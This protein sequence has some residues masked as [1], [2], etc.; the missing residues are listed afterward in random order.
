MLP[1]MDVVATFLP[2]LY[3]TWTLTAIIPDG[4]TITRTFTSMEETLTFVAA[5]NVDK[6]IYYTLNVAKP[7]LT[8]KPSKSDILEACW[9]H[10]DLDPDEGESPETAK[11]RYIAKLAAFK[12]K[13]TMIIDSGN[14]I[15]AI[16]R[17]YAV[18]PE[19]FAQVERVSKW[20]MEELG[21]KAGTQN[22]DRI[23]RLPGTINWPN[24]VKLE[25]GCV[26]VRSQYLSYNELC[27]YDL[28][29]FELPPETVATT[30]SETVDALD[31]DPL[32]W[33]IHTGGR[34][35]TQGE[36]SEGVWWCLNEL[37]RR[38]YSP[39]CVKQIML[40]RGNRITTHIY[41]QARPAS[42]VDT[43]IESA[44]TKFKFVL[45][46]RTQKPVSCHYNL[47]IALLK[48]GIVV[49]YDE[50]TD[51]THIEGLE[52]RDRLTDVAALDLRV[53]CHD[54]Y[55]FTPAK[56]MTFE[57]LDTI[58]QRNRYHPVK[59][60]FA[61]L[62]W[63]G[64]K[65]L[66]H[67][68]SIY[69]QAA[70][71]PYT[72]TVGALM[73]V[74]AVRRIKYPGTKFDE[75]VVLESPVQGTNKSS[76]LEVLASTEWFSDNLPFSLDSKQVIEV[77]R[78]RLIVEA[79]ELSGMRRT[80]VEHMKAFLSRTV[81]R[82]RMAYDRKTVNV[83]RQCIIV[84]TTNDNKYL[85]DTGG[86]RRFWPVRV[87]RFDLDALRRDR[88]QLWAEAIVRENDGA[89]IQMEPGL[90]EV[91][92]EQQMDRVIN[93]P[94]TDTL[95][96]YL[97]GFKEGKITRNDVVMIIGGS[98]ASW[99]QDQNGRLGKAMET[100]GWRRPGS[101]G[102][103]RYDGRQVV[104]WLI[105]EGNPSQ[106]PLITA[107]KDRDTNQIIVSIEGGLS[108]SEDSRDDSF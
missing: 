75:M 74:A 52:D 102:Q 14:G 6:N 94:Y 73:L 61:S 79:A 105:G 92:A 101:N 45:D 11:T 10:A 46:Q 88:D 40:D 32:W 55:K 84:G 99:T 78:G 100:L 44:R 87:K 60:Y 65:R 107:Y 12:Y 22:I 24:K 4:K 80:E 63:D 38:G 19:R 34:Y 59:D 85:K 95:R 58:A 47:I 66:D 7:G 33:T 43:Q 103:F 93:D 77:L 49:R 48:L 37:L 67:W 39:K 5:H 26:P 30:A 104:G 17:I 18:G 72:N 41:D 3:A 69:G 70:D 108:N 106:L 16:W 36:R 71:T 76:T 9:V 89:S 97:A 54:V 82:G 1:D 27:V 28:D 35:Q 42:Y 21:S 15:Q 64:V 13:P 2:R 20:I 25:R 57:V 90:W 83:P 50:F 91:A 8:K 23:L 56:E 53:L 51:S 29:D 96:H 81:D 86:N 31:H 68:L 62:K 98:P